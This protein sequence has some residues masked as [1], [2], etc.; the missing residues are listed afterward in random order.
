MPTITVGLDGSPESLAAADWA[1]REAVQRQAPLRLLHAGPSS[2]S[3]H[4]PFPGVPAPD[5][6]EAQRAWAAHLLRE[7]ESRLRDRHP[8]LRITTEQADEQAAPALLAGAEDTEL[9]VLGSRG[10]GAVAGFLVGSVALAVVARS[11][12]PVVLVRAGEHAADEHLPDATGGAAASSSPY[13][14]VVLGLDLEEPGDAVVEFAFETAARRAA[15]LRVVH[16]WNPAAVFGHAAAPDSELDAELAE[17]TRLG[18]H[19]LLR[20]WRGKFPGVEVRA[21]AVIGSAGRHLVHASRD[22]SLVVVGR[23]RRH[24]LVGG[25]VG[26]VAHA[27]LQHASAPVAVVPHD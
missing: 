6:I 9:L 8:G 2:G 26:P 10:L 12:R 21:Q 5:A 25:R 7:A 17:E 20:P 1:A 24:A 13:R 11:E 3:P 4:P 22:A 14:D 23:K 16:G 27:V 18:L 15:G 19:D